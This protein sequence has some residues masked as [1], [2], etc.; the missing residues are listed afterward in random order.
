MIVSRFHVE[1]GQGILVGGVHDEHRKKACRF[2]FARV[3]GT[4]MMGT[5]CC[6]QTGDNTRS[7][8][9]VDAFTRF[10]R[11]LNLLE[12]LLLPD[13]IVECRNGV[14]STGQI[15]AQRHIQVAEFRY[16]CL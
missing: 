13:R 12:E 2:S 7:K 11:I 9:Q 5:R 14:C 8:S 3:L 15:S 4:N 1:G 6:R 16:A 10:G